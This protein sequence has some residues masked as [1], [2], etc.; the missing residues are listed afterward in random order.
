M[1]LSGFENDRV[2]VLEYKDTPGAMTNAHR[3]L[4]R[5]FHASAIRA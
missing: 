3:K 2:R 5:I 1:T 4:V